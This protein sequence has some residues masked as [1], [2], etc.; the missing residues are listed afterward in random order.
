MYILYIRILYIIHTH[1][2]LHIQTDS[3]GQA[4][5]CVNNLLQDGEDGLM[6]ADFAR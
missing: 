2:C 1:T 4:L 6:T 3:L 5:H